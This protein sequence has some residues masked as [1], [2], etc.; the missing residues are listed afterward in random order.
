M[1]RA[2]EIDEMHEASEDSR[3]VKQKMANL[4]DK[5]AALVKYNTISSCSGIV[6]FNGQFL[7]SVVFSCW[8]CSGV[9]TEL[10]PLEDK[11]HELPGDCPVCRSKE[12]LITV[13]HESLSEPYQAAKQLQREGVDS[14]ETKVA[15]KVLGSIHD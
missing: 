9:W 10:Y 5:L 15:E 14:L 4:V 11:M 2:L 7:N 6:R 3:R 8:Q 12:M 1:D 13:I